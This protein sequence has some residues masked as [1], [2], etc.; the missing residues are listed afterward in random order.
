MFLRIT[1][2]FA[3][4]TISLHDLHAQSFQ[5]ILRK[6]DLSYHSIRKLVKVSDAEFVCLT[7]TDLYRMDQQGNILSQKTIGTSDHDLQDISITTT[8]QFLL[9]GG[10]YSGPSP[11]IRVT[12]LGS[13]GDILGQKEFDLN[14]GSFDNLYVLPSGPD[15]LFLL[16]VHWEQGRKHVDIMY[17]NKDLNIVWQH[18]QG[19]EV[20]NTLHVIPGSNDGV[21]FLFDSPDTRD[22]HHFKVD[23]DQNLIE[24]PIEYRG[25]KD[26]ITHIRKMVKTP[27]G[28]YLYTGVENSGYKFED[29]LLLKTDQ[30][31]STEFVTKHDFYLGDTDDAISTVDDGYIA[32][33]RTGYNPNDQYMNSMDIALIKFDLAGQPLWIKAY[34]TSL[35]DYGRSMLI[36][37]D[38]SFTIAGQATTYYL[39]TSEPVIIRTDAEGNFP[40]QSFPHP[41]MTPSPV[42]RVQADPSSNIQRMTGGAL[43]PD[44][45]MIMSQSMLDAETSWFYPYITRSDA[46]G[47][48]VWHHAS[49][50]GYE[51][52]L[53]KPMSDGSFLSVTTTAWQDDFHVTKLDADGKEDWTKTFKA[54]YIKD[55]VMAPDGGYL[56]CGMEFDGSGAITRS[57]LVIKLNKQGDEVWRYR[58]KIDRKW[59]VGRSIQITPE[60]DIL[61]A[62]Y[63]QDQQSPVAS[64]YLAKLSEQG[65]LTWHKTF[66]HGNNI[67]VANK[68]IITSTKDYLLTGYVNYPGDLN[69]QDLLLI[70]T[71]P[72]GSLLWEKEYNIDKQDAGN[73]IIEYGGQYY[74][75]GTT[76]QP[77]FGAKESFGLLLKTDLN[78]I[79]QGFSA[80]G[81]KGT[82]LTC[83][84]MYA[85]AEN[86]LHF[87]G[88]VQQPFGVERLFQA[89]LQPGQI[90][91]SAGPSGNRNVMIYPVPA[92]NTAYLMIDHQ[93]MGD[94]RITITGISG[95]QLHHF[96]TQKTQPRVNIP[97]PVSMLAAGTYIVELQFGQHR[98]QRKLV[99]GK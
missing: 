12:R 9:A 52:I 47:N 70:K 97:L 77:S 22:P 49:S 8:G 38:G 88:T 92:S 7:N 84:E 91:G 93:Y 53:L 31:G 33:I 65:S 4:C 81:N 46:Q 62:G 58:H 61:V 25:P 51:S 1:I 41:L 96:K 86:K 99:I 94:I 80:F 67:A 68:V 39:T 15:H 73:S 69:K 27:D 6:A 10:V 82:N 13:N 14:G 17:L 20:Y 36:N 5:K 64:A 28:G 26:A 37:N 72:Q 43:L 45:G 90:L 35:V 29:L 18:H 59:I 21:E 71:N 19:M 30:K 79:Q 42:E 95:V 24:Q 83:T 85:D 56:L 78:G 55:A 87:M 54:K 66:P 11:A 75:A 23:T 57:L 16:Y 32:M 3:L 2:I 44:G 63:M 48:I 98:F 34:G 40:Q 76:G 60:K 50:A 89:V 74:I